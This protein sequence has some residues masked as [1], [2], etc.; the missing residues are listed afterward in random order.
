MAGQD[1]VENLILRIG[2]LTIQVNRELAASSSGFRVHHLGPAATDPNE[3]PAGSSAGVFSV[4]KAK[5]KGKAKGKGRA[6][7]G[8]RYYVVTHWAVNPEWT[9]IYHGPW[10]RFSRDI[11]EGPLSGSGASLGA[12]D[13]AAEARAYW[14]T[15]F[16]WH[17]DA[18]FDQ[19]ILEV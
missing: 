8:P 7:P 18:G 12:F 13:S 3:L 6:P 2:E 5:A 1:S 17:E 11:L 15:V 4:P 19:P 9:G 10:S 16:P 14:Q